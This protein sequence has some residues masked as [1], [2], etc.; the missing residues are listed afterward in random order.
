MSLIVEE[1][2]DIELYVHILM[3]MGRHVLA[4]TSGGIDSVRTDGG[5]CH[6]FKIPRPGGKARLILDATTGI[7]ESNL[8]PSFS[9]PQCETIRLETE[10]GG[11]PEK[12]LK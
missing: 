6:H 2:Y 1:F 3:T 10:N 7:E 11:V 12:E 5:Y 9:L 8:P 4:M